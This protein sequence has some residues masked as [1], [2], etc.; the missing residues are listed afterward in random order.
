MR[1]KIAILAGMIGNKVVQMA[2]RKGT[3][4][5]GKIALAVKPDILNDFAKKCDKIALITGTNGKTTTNNLAN[6]IFKGKD[7]DIVS[8][9]NG[10]NMITGVTSSFIQNHR[11]HYNW[12]IYEV[13]E[14]SMPNVTR[15]L[16]SNYIIITNFFRDQLDRY[17]EVENT[18]N[19]VQKSSKRHNSTLILDADSPISLYFQDSDQPKVYYSLKK[20]PFSKDSANVEESV[21]CPVCGHK[22]DYEYINYGNHVNFHVPN[23]GLKT[24]KQIM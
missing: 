14:G 7:Y 21:F 17:G 4:L 16:P 1:S 12:G 11:D 3:S 5:T 23:A 6:H 19:L 20:N 24:M 10:S 9:L 15:Y 13:D 2:G 8:N 18:I 22:L